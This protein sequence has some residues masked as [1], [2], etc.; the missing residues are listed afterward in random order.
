MKKTLISIAAVAFVALMITNAY[1][2]I[3]VT[4]PPHCTLRCPGLTPGFWKHNIEV[5]LGY[6]NGAYSALPDGTKLTNG[7]METYLAGIQSGV[8]PDYP[9][10]PGLTF[11]QA[12]TF[13]KGPGWSADRTNIA[14]WFNF[15][16]GYGWF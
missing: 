3:C 9:G 5:Y 12:L 16:A 13:L 1:A 15:E 14:N 10:I 2:V 8:L 7:L 4:T 11:D 6:T